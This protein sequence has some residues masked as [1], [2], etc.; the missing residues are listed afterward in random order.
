MVLGTLRAYRMAMSELAAMSHLNMDSED[1]PR[2][3]THLDSST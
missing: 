3:K 2:N 1:D